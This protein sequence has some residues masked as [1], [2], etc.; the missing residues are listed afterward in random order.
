MN[1]EYPKIP[2]GGGG[3]TLTQLDGLSAATLG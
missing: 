1:I 3:D 2:R